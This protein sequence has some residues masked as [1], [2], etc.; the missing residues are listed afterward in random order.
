MSDDKYIGI[1]VLSQSVNS[2]T[3]MIKDRN[4]LLNSMYKK[5]VYNDFLMSEAA[6]GGTGGA[7]VD[8][9]ISA[10]G[11]GAPNLA[12]PIEPARKNYVNVEQAGGSGNVGGAS[13]NGEP[14]LTRSYKGGGVSA[15]TIKASK[16]RT[17][18]SGFN[19]Q[20]KS[21]TK[22][23]EETGFD[24]TVE[25]NISNK[26]EKDFQIDPRLKK[27]F[28]DS[29]ALPI[30]AAGAALMGLIAKIPNI[31]PMM[32]NVGNFI[33]KIGSSL[34]L[35]NTSSTDSSTKTDT[36]I[37]TNKYNLTEKRSMSLSDRGMTVPPITQMGQKPLAGSNFGKS[38][39]S[40]VNPGGGQG[41]GN[42]VSTVKNFFGLAK[43]K[44]H[45][46]S[47]ETMMG[48]VVN[49][50]QKRRM[51]I[52]MFGDESIG[53]GTTGG[54]MNIMND[55]T[56]SMSTIQSGDSFKNISK[57]LVT[58]MSGIANSSSTKSMITDLTNNVINEGN[59]LLNEQGGVEGIKEQMSGMIKQAKA[60]IPNLDMESGGSMAISTVK[61]SP[62]FTEYANTAQF[63]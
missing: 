58:S 6:Q 18:P 45:Q 50:L 40:D 17:A 42:I 47:P 21:S 63:S 37:S 52:E 16:G 57:N 23:L 2:M 48:G 27:A 10:I 12:A 44:D 5:D 15:P 1:E 30:K 35:F 26:L 43:D 62:F 28:G 25:K 31:V 60:S 38:K 46:V 34:G 39:K 22:S 7:G 9:A 61:Q 51:M 3:E 56:S 13:D 32:S 55:L 59:A 19:P 49:N 54:L 8:G 4:A 24:D 29:L 36:N 33:T 11:G 53:G 20:E 14:G 41:G